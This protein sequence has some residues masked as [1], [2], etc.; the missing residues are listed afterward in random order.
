MSR[1]SMDLYRKHDAPDKLKTYG[2]ATSDTRVSTCAIWTIA[3]KC[4]DLL[5][6]V[7]GD[8]VATAPDFPGAMPKCLSLAEASLP[9][10]A[11]QDSLSA[12]LQVVARGCAQSAR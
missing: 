1:S 9:R 12:Q 7:V 10:E 11:S 5:I 6:N 8:C 4:L 3:D 2:R